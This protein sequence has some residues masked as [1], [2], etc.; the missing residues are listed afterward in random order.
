M[1]GYICFAKGKAIESGWESCVSLLFKERT[2]TCI[3]TFF[4][5]STCRCFAEIF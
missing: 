1:E 5:V 2:F 3:G 4:G